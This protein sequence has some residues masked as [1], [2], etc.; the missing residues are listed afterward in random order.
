[1]E[2]LKIRYT[3]PVLVS[4]FF[5]WGFLTCMNDILI[6]YLKKIFTLNYAEAMVIQFTFFGAYFIGSWLYYVF[7]IRLSDPIQKIGYK[8]G[9]VFGLLLSSLGTA[10]FYPATL[11]HSYYVFLL[12]LFILGLGFTLLQISA[13]PYVAIIGDPQTASARLN[14]AQGFNSLG[15]TIAPLIGGYW[16]FT[17]FSKHFDNT[18]GALVVPYLLFTAIFLVM[19]VFFYFIKLPDFKVSQSTEKFKLSDYPQLY[20]GIIAIFMYVG[21][22]VSIGS[23]LINFLKEPHIG[24]LTESEASRYVSLYWAGLMFGRFLGSIFLTEKRSVQKFLGLIVLLVLSFI[25]LSLVHHTKV[26]AFYS[27]VI[28]VAALILWRMYKP[29]TSLLVFSLINVVLLLI[30]L[31]FNG[32]LVIS[33]VV[34]IG[35]FN[36]I[37]WSNIFTLSIHQLGIHT[38]RASS[39]LVMAIVG[40]AVLPLLMGLVADHLTIQMSFIV[41]LIG[42]IYLTFF[43]VKIHK[44]VSL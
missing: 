5:M 25:F 36:S 10:C 28:S 32:K 39:L 7:S 43:S 6:P 31:L 29:Q 1:M 41:P 27:V 33:A 37:M 13:N 9:I 4:L 44:I 23:M 15:T 12:G 38:S 16:V 21:S 24:N 8:N 14:L 18:S 22:E 2:R 19:A 3:F 34:L 17:Y 35:L 11:M 20:W 40:G 42:Y 30:V 26:A